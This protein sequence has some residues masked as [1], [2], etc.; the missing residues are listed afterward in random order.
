MIFLLVLIGVTAFSI[1]LAIRR[2]TSSARQSEAQ[3]RTITQQLVNIRLQEVVEADKVAAARA[4]MRRTA[5]TV[6]RLP[7]PPPSL[8]EDRLIPRKAPERPH[9]AGRGAEVSGG[10]T[11][12]SATISV[13]A[14]GSA[15]R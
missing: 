7:A 10:G 3:L 11:S 6:K 5:E 13:I 2:S 15:A 9:G 14:T 12:A 1:G 4:L 8:I